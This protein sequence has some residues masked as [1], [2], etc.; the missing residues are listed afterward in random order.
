LIIKGFYKKEFCAES[1]FH[2]KVTLWHNC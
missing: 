2:L 1:A